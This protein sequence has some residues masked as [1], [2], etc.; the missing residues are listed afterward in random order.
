[1]KGRCLNPNATHYHR[2]GGRGITI[3]QPWVESFSSF[4]ADIGEPP[5]PKHSLDRIDNSKGYTPENTRWAT[6][7]EQSN[8]RE[9]NIRVTSKGKTMT[10]MQW[11]EE[12]GVPYMLLIDRY[13]KGERGDKLVEP[14]RQKP[15]SNPVPFKGVSKTLREWA[16]LSKVPYHELWKRRK[17]GVDLFTEEEW[18]RFTN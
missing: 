8:N 11:A 18:N 3:H 7:K 2:Y 10:L 1:M 6:K 14:R 16:V 17:Y 4:L 5:T 12:L 15:R 9:N 13:V